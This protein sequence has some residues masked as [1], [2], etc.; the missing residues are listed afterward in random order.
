LDRRALGEHG[1]E[2]ARRALGTNGYKVVAT[3]LRVAGVE[4]DIIATRRIGLQR[5]VL[6]VEVKTARWPRVAETNL[7]ERQLARLHRAAAALPAALGLRRAHVELWLCAITV[8]KDAE[9]ELRWFGIGQSG[10]N[11]SPSG[12]R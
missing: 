2:L 8:G 11:P 9:V 10:G 5:R 1:E 12:L 7:R 6:V 4:L 3:N